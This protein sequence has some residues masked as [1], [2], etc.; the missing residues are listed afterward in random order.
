MPLTQDDIRRHY[1]TA[2][3]PADDGHD[4]QAKMRYG[5]PAANDVMLPIFEQM[6]RDLAVRVDGGRVLDVGCG[7]GRWTR[8]LLEKFAPREL[9]GADYTQASVD[10]LNTWAKIEP[11]PQTQ[12]R[13]EIHDITSPDVTIPGEFDLIVIG[14]VLFHIPEPDKFTH[15]MAN[16]ARL[17]GPTG[18]IVTTEYLPRTTMRTEW[19]LVRSRY[20]FEAACKTAGLR[21]VDIRPCAFFTNDPMGLDGPNEACRNHFHIVRSGFQQL[22]KISNGTLANDIARFMTAV[23][24]CLL[25][26]CNERLAP[27]DFPSQKFVVLARA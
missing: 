27:V 1:E 18:R 25:A 6:L 26:Y 5:N 13:F 23:D 8:C 7:A 24:R 4:V 21:I 22:A 10:L 16:L 17:A 3:K 11:H 15:A 20:E 14:N 2:W 12:V 9:L 19:M